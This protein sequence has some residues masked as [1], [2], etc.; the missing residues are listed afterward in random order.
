[1]PFNMIGYGLKSLA[2]P[3]TAV[4]LQ[5]GQYAV[6]PSGQYLIQLGK[7][8]LLQWYDP[9][10]TTWRNFNA[11]SAGSVFPMISDGYNYRIMN[12]TGTVVGGVVTTGGT[13]NT[14]KNGIWPAG[15]SSTTGA[16]ATTTAGA[17]APAL[18]AQFNVIVGGSIQQSATVTSGG[19]GYVVPPLVTFSPP[20]AGGLLP[21]AYAVLTAGAVS[22][23]TVVDQGAGYQTAP[24]ITLTPVAND[25][26]TGAA[27]TAYLVTSTTGGNGQAV[28]VTMANY[29][30]GYA[31]VPTVTCAGLTSMAVTAVCCFAVTTA[32]TISSATHY[33]NL[34]N[35]VNFPAQPTAATQFGSMKNP[36]YTTNLFNMRNG[37]AVPGTSA[38][39]GSLAILDAGMS[40]L[41]VSNLPS[42]TWSSDGTIPAAYTSASGASGGVASDI[43][44]V[45]P[46]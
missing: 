3:S 28:A 18:T 5:S 9:V 17:N 41:D 24:T 27:A 2:N 1:M 6:L 42:V 11:L 22:S 26:G 25:P 10:S 30:G 12:V 13:S 16:T 32:P 40:Q 38:S 20:P 19:S 21:T 8:S 15:S 23:I 4:T 33:G 36:S 35:Q 45:I 37:L 46:L 7:Y 34:V 14:A 43:S 29:G 39:L 44:Y 31:T